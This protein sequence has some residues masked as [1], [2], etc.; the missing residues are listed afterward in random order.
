MKKILIVD[1]EA[2]VL[3]AYQEFLAQDPFEVKCV[4]DTSSA[5]Y[6][7]DR[8]DYSLLISDI[9]IDEENGIDLIE[10][11][12]EKYPHIKILAVSGGGDA[13]KFLAGMALEKAVELGADKG[14]IKPF[15]EEKFRSLVKRLI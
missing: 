13:G 11:V 5:L 4:Q 10:E 6:E 3:E 7:L 14:L 9:L 2:N 12:R 1:D 8:E 15:E